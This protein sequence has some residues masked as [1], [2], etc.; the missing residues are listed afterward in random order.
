MWTLKLKLMMAST[1]EPHSYN[2]LLPSVDL[3][4]ETA[5]TMRTAVAKHQILA[6]FKYKVHQN[7]HNNIYRSVSKIQQSED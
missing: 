6:V 7:C 2:C 4:L 1:A 3:S 5:L